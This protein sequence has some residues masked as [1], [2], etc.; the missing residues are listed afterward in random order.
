MKTP[1]QIISSTSEYDILWDGEFEPEPELQEEAES[2]WIKAVR[3]RPE[4]TDDFLLTFNSAGI[5]NNRT[6]VRCTKTSYR[7]YF[8]AHSAPGL[9]PPLEPMSVSGVIRV[10]SPG[11]PAYLVARRSRKV[12]LY[13]NF[14]EFIPSGGIDGKAMSDGG[15]VDFIDQFK[16]EFEEESG[17]DRAFITSIEPFALIKDIEGE[18]YDVC[19][20]IDVSCGADDLFDALAANNE[21]SDFRLVSHDSLQQFIKDNR[22]VFVPTSMAIACQLLENSPD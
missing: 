14:L 19:A 22:H 16:R 5:S 15:A 3:K 1:W 4:L 11:G 18:V 13:K 12:T 2:I 9:F 21:Y 6:T 8:A 10:A 17:L 20:V 7:Y